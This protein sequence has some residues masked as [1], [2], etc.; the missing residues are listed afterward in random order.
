MIT[1]SSVSILNAIPLGIGSV[2]P[3][4]LKF[5]TNIEKGFESYSRDHKILKIA[6]N[7]NIKNIKIVKKSEIP[8][9]VG[10]KSSSAY[11]TSLIGAYAEFKKIKIEDIQIARLSSTVSKKIGISITGAFDDAFGSLT[12]KIPVTDNIKMEIID[13]YDSFNLPV[14]ITV[15]ELKRSMDLKERLISRKNDFLRALEHLKKGE[16]VECAN[17][18]GYAVGRALGYPVEPITNVRKLGA[19]ISGYTGNGPAF[20]SITEKSNVNEVMEFM[21]KFGKTFF[22]EAYRND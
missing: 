21:S 11:T 1:H 4:N 8:P 7:E 13:I 2:M 15:P 14:I 18:N 6:T 3:I 22:V 12:E 9:G 17:I 10:L 16:I 20:F 5:V 19:L